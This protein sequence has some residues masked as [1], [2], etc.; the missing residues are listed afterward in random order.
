MK[1]ALHLLNGLG[2]KRIQVLEEHGIRDVESLLEWIP[3]R[4]LDRTKIQKIA[5][6]EEFRE[7]QIRAQVLRV[8][9]VFGKTPRLLATVSDGS[10][11]IDLVFFNQIPALSKRLQ[12]GTEW[13]VV[14]RVTRFGRLQMTHPELEALDSTGQV[15]GPK[16][17]PVYPS[18]E[19]LK[20]SRIDQRALRKWITEGLALSTIR[21]D[22]VLPQKIQTDLNLHSR[23]HCLR[24][25]HNPQSFAE[26]FESRRQLKIEEILPIAMSMAWRRRA[27]R[28][29][30]R[31]L[32]ATGLKL[33][34]F[35]ASLP[36]EL[37]PGQEKAFA[38]LQKGM[39]TALQYQALVQGDVGSGKTVIAAMCVFHA[40][41]A[42]VQA[43]LLAPTEILARQHGE[44]FEQWAGALGF[45]SAL[46]LGSTPARERSAML[47]AY[48]AGELDVLIGTHALFSADVRPA[49]L[50]LVV[51][52][53]QHR[54]GVGQRQ[55]LM[56]KGLAP[57]LISLTATPIPRS[58]AMT[59][60]GDMES[61]I[62]EGKPQG[63]KPIQS[64]L[65]PM[66]KRADLIRWAGKQL[67][68]GERIYWVAPKVSA[69]EDGEGGASVSSLFE[70]LQVHFPEQVA[71]VHGQM[72]DEEKLANLMAF[73]RGEIPLLV[74]T[75]VIEVG[76]NVPE[77]N[78]MIIEGADRFGLS[79]LH[80][81]R[82]RVGR[83]QKEA[84]CFL[85]TENEEAEA[86]LKGFAA[87]EDG[88]A[89][90]EMD[91]ELRGA[92]DLMGQSQSG[93]KPFKY[94]DFV[95]DLELVVEMREYSEQCL[96]LK[97]PGVQKW[98]VDLVSQNEDLAKLD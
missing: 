44:A 10:G 48:E 56:S 81:L 66:A 67:E 79:Q 62:M 69:S 2:A 64:R 37:T 68:I 6:L 94:F 36:F 76:V 20:S 85:L 57:D 33:A 14:G 31:A 50:G 41:E 16:I 88:F 77:A 74:A 80:Q 93:Q 35:K 72:G 12:K 46:L 4:Y 97:D 47:A 49:N 65:V 58:L 63:R 23:L 26:V 21:L 45:R 96:E 54:F 34:E 9:P 82:G 22:C 17:V 90:S 95:T 92:G 59:W 73:K 83:G 30:G 89:I 86:R 70:E 60:Y 51:V 98:I 52:D 19:S 8:G 91:L 42:G 87:T 13:L 1:H 25:L 28:A 27:Q 43:A 5:E 71:M 11:E 78:V 53:E 7:A 15:E 24:K 40:L 61:V 18:T 29:R 39:S 38:R 55:A 32:R 3:R 84:W 75:T